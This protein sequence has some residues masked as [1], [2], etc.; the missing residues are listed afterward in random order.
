MPARARLHRLYRRAPGEGLLCHN[1]AEPAPTKNQALCGLFFGP[2]QWL[3]VAPR[4]GAS[5]RGWGAGAG[6]GGTSRFFSFQLGLLVRSREGFPLVWGASGTG[7]GADYEIFKFGHLWH[8]RGQW[9]SALV[10]RNVT[11]HPIDTGELK[12]ADL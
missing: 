6:R 9:G 7:S 10:E 12:Q 3:G 4:G 2:A 5:R 11:F 8:Q 1:V